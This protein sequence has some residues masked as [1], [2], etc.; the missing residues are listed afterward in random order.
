MKIKRIIVFSFLLS[1]SSIKLLGCIYNVRDVGF[2]EIVFNPYRLY[3]IVQDNTPEELITLFKQIAY[4]IFMDSNF[5]VE[6]INVDRDSGHPA[7][8]YSHFWEIRSFPAAILVSPTGRSM[9]LPI[10]VSENT[11]G[12]AVRNS[13]ENVVSSSIREEILDHIVKAY[14]IILL[15]EGNNAAENKRV[16]KIVRASVQKID[17]IMSQLPKRIEE[18]PQIIVIPR[19]LTSKERILLW[20]LDLDEN[21]LNEPCLAVIYGRARRIGPLLKGGQ[22]TERTLFN[23]LS[24]IGL[25]CE[26]GLDKKWMMG[27][28]LPIMWGERIQQ[29]VA[30]ILGFDAESPMV[31]MEM[32]N[33]ISFDYYTKTEYREN[34]IDSESPFDRYKEELLKFENEWSE[35]RLSPAQFR[36]IVSPEPADSKSGPNWKLIISII[37]IFVLVIMAGGIFILLLLRRKTS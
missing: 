13:L 5:K 31:K 1:L 16:D 10:S 15:I 9:I 25:S 24:L 26:C 33:I 35:K 32:S 11:Y 37:G 4:P 22:I 2:V 17:R 3:Y 6:I 14:S 21:Q 34:P 12:G 36:D 7:L 29:D 28:R 20:S 18:P 8:E 30:N 19:E 27:P 23:I